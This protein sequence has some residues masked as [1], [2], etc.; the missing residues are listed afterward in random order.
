MLTVA[1]V[2]AD[3]T[4]D[5]LLQAAR[6]GSSNIHLESTKVWFLISSDSVGT[7]NLHI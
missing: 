1:P 2:T 5:V 3:S 6:V 4:K 7:R